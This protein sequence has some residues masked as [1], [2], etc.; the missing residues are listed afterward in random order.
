MEGND[1]AMSF[2]QTRKTKTAFRKPVLFGAAALLAAG[3]TGTSLTSLSGPAHAEQ[4]LNSS[5]LAPY[6]RAPL[7][8]ADLVERVRPSVVSIYIT[9]KQKTPVA[10]NGRDIPDIPE[11]HPLFKFFKKFKKDFEPRGK[12]RGSNP[13]RRPKRPM[14]AQGSGFIISQDGFVV[15]NHHVINNASKIK[16]GLVDGKQYDAKLI[17]SDKRTDIALLKI[18]KK[19]TFPFVPFANSNKVRVG[20]WV[21]A[22]GNPF[23]LSSTVTAGIVSHKNRDIG[24]GP[25]DFLQIDAAVNKGNSGGP[26]FN[27]AGEVIGVN[28]A[29]Y[30]Q[31][32]G[33]VGIA[34][35]VPAET[36]SNVIEQLKENGSVQRGWLGV[37]IQSVDE[38]IAASMGMDDPHGALIAQITEDG[39]A[40]RSSLK[41]GDI[42][43]HVNGEKVKDSREL[44]REI[45]KLNPKSMANLTVLS[46]GEEARVSVKLGTFPNEKKL[47]SLKFGK[48]A[49]GR[50]LKALGLTLAPA[51]EFSETKEKGVVITDVDPDS[52]AAEKGL[53]NG[54]I[55]LGI[56]SRTVEKPREVSR[57]IKRAQKSG[58]R[59]VLLRVRSS[60]GRGERFI[61]LPIKKRG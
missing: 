43:T 52:S 46:K 39:P 18:I 16:V 58:R 45:A 51:S 61:A 26:A 8:F 7:S 50:K 27:L 13:G 17:G 15:T 6:P 22:V 30:S 54:D 38:D 21:I 24:S 25:Y 29:I 40:S 57:I 28:S 32:G 5:A 47:A 41:S 2:Q 4:N 3:L 59:A 60:S 37:Q 31:S 35:A 49:E 44:A 9:S 1:Q 36:A 20:D 42:V 14:R 12:N 33:N 56:N 11:D 19:E 53:Q 23:G 34:F 10:F 55:I 48:N